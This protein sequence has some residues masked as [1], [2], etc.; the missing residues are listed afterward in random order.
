MY[1]GDF[2]DRCAE[3]IPLWSMAGRVELSSVHRWERESPSV[4]AEFNLGL[5]ADSCSNNHLHKKVWP[6]KKS[7][8]HGVVFHLAGLEVY[9]CN[10]PYLEDCKSN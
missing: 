1:E 2:S 8:F 4:C 5:M 9:N 6:I 10:E 7:V 3:K